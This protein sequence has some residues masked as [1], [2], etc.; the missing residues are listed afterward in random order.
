ME[1]DRENWKMRAICH[2]SGNYVAHSNAFDDLKVMLVTEGNHIGLH[3]APE[4]IK[5]Q[6]AKCSLNVRNYYR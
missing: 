4:D 3:R 1:G 6:K 2:T 5:L